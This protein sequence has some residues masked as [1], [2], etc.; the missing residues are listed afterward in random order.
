MIGEHGLEDVRESSVL[1]CGA[2]PLGAEIGNFTCSEKKAE[3]KSEQR[4]LISVE[5]FRSY[6]FF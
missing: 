3:R 6:F 5:K 1:I 2:G 4:T